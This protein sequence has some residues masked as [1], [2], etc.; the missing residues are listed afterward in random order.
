MGRRGFT[1]IELLV[2][3]LIIGVLATIAIPKFRAVKD[4]AYVVSMQSDLRGAVMAQ[5]SYAE[6]QRPSTFASTVADLGTSFRPSSGVTIEF[7]DVS[8][9][10]FGALATHESTDRRCAVFQGAAPVAPAIEEGKVACD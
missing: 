7:S 8:A 5:I 6:A 4:R 1:L 9:T 10:G 2:V 3:V